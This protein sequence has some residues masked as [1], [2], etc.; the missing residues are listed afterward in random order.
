MN[1]LAGVARGFGFFVGA[2]VVVGLV[3]VI[4]SRIF[5]S[6]PW[7]TDAGQWI[8]QALD[9]SNLKSIESLEFLRNSEGNIVKIIPTIQ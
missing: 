6:I 9:P 1:L 4:L 7:L 3:T 8:K 5:I 2:T